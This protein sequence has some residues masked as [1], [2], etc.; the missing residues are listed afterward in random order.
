MIENIVLIDLDGTLCDYQDRLFRDLE[1]ISS[2]DDP[3]VKDL[4]NTPPWI[5]KRIDLIRSVPGWW[6]SL[7]PIESGFDILEMCNDIGFD[8]RIL[9]KGPRRTKIAW[10]EKVEWVHENV[11]PDYPNTQVTI[12]EDKG[13]VYGKVLVDDFGPYMNRWLKW[14]PRGLGIMP[15]T[16]WNKDYY[17]PNVIRYDGTNKQ[18]VKEA[19]KVCYERLPKSQDV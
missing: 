19:L 9:T 3:K 5:E 16:N 8:I 14:R 1:L 13:L 12:T 6:K 4:H 17:H 11:V 18:E 10:T 7:K 2:P 15:V